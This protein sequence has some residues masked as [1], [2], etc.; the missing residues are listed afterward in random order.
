MRLFI[1]GTLLLLAT[2]QMSPAQDGPR[3][4]DK[5]DAALIAASVADVW[6]S[7]GLLEGNPLARGADGR[8]S[9]WKGAALKGGAF[10][11]FKLAEWRI[12]SERK[13]IRI[14]KWTATGAFTAMAVRGFF[15][16]RNR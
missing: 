4:F 1:L 2:A 10:A 5:S 7:R 6:A 13:A 14:G 9:V 8:L 15:I 11:A 3:A 12:P 16:K